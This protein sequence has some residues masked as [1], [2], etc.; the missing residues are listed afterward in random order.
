M[1]ESEDMASEYQE[2]LEEYMQETAKRK[3]IINCPAYSE[4]LSIR[5]HSP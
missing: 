4:F 2:G 5:E 1:G 3:S